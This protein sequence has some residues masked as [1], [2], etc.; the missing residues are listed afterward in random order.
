MLTARL[1]AHRTWNSHFLRSSMHSTNMAHASSISS[2]MADSCGRR[3][4]KASST[5]E[6]HHELV[7]K[8]V[9]KKIHA[10]SDPSAHL[11]IQS[12]RC[13]VI[14]DVS[15]L[16]ISPSTSIIDAG[17]TSAVAAAIAA[18]LKHRDLMHG[19]M[20]SLTGV[21]TRQYSSL[22]ARATSPSLL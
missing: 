17:T 3:G 1:H 5:E 9:S 18:A 13:K 7:E 2:F 6:T 19:S 11:C 15:I 12:D 4:G 22:V 8:S 10:V 20:P 21:I 16:P 14:Q